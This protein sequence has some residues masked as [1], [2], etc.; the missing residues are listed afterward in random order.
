MSGRFWASAL[1]CSVFAL[2]HCGGTVVTTADGSGGAAGRGHAGRTGQAGR[3]SIAGSG[4][5]D[6]LPDAGFDA[7]VDPGC[8]DVGAPV[9]VKECDPFATTP[10][11][12]DGEGCFPFVDHPQ[13]GCDPQRFGAECRPSG[14]G[15]QGDTCGSPGQSCAAGFVCVVG[16]QPGKH[17]VQLCRI[18]SQKACPAGMICGELDVEGYG[19][20]S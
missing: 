18:G 15:Q 6:T 17:C 7:Y 10:T 3:S 4:G 12:P 2:L 5:S 16:S 8:P 1:L 19:V 9:E 13:V 11:C 14:T 20:C